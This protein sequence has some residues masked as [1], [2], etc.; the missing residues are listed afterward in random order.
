MGRPEKT[1]RFDGHRIYEVLRRCQAI[2]VNVT[3]LKLSNKNIKGEDPWQ[4]LT[5]FF[6]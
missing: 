3:S 4:K 2:V 6:S 5:L 1:L